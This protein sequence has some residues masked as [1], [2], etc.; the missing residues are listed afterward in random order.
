MTAQFI[1]NLASFVV[2]VVF[3]TSFWFGVA[4]ILALS[5]QYPYGGVERLTV[6]GCTFLLTLWVWALLRIMGEE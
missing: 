1:H 2:L 5:F 6:G 4:E 3:P